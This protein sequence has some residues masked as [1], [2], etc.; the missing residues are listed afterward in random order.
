MSVIGLNESDQDN[1]LR[2]VA[3]IL[4]LGNVSFTEEKNFARVNDE[5]C[6]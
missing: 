5:Q 3:A 4:H 6:N 1:I 2:L